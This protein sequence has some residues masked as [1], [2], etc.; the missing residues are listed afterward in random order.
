VV[1]PSFDG[2]IPE[3]AAPTDVP[4]KPDATSEDVAAPPDVSEP[5]VAAVDVG[6]PQ[7]VTADVEPDAAPVVITTCSG[8]IDCTSACNPGDAICHTACDGAATDDAKQALAAF[9]ACSVGKCPG[10]QGE[11]Y[12]SCMLAG[13]LDETAACW[14]GGDATCSELLWCSLDCVGGG[15]EEACGAACV[16]EASE[17]AFKQFGQ[18]STCLDGACQ[19]EA[20]F[21]GGVATF[22]CTDAASACGLYTGSKSCGDGVQCLADCTSAKCVLECQGS[23]SADAGKKAKKFFECLLKECGEDATQGCIE[24]ASKGSCGIQAAGCFF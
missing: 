20:L 24:S 11:P 4:G 1:E 19:T 23:M 5:D 22:L 21:C 10:L 15:A 6:T 2:G 13:C 12:V 16:G 3:D 17:A 7:D 9:E 18:Y 14:T 8:I